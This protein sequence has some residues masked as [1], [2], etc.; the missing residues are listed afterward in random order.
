M[1]IKKKP[2]KKKASPAKAKVSKAKE[3]S[4]FASVFSSLSKEF[5]GGVLVMTGANSAVG[6]RSM[7]VRYFFLDEVIPEG[8][9]RTWTA[10]TP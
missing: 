1:A 7:P 8:R 9:W 3:A 6:L 5:P 4:T 2:V 10:R